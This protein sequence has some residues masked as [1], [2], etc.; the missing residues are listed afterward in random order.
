MNEEK[1]LENI[2]KSCK[3]AKIVSKIS[4][5]LLI[6]GTVLTLFSGIYLLA[7]RKSMDEKIIEASQSGKK[8]NV[9]LKAGP[10]VLGEIK[11][12][13]F[14]AKEKVESSNP[15]LNAY[16]EANSDSPSLLLGF[17]ALLIGIIL[18]FASV[19]FYFITSIFDI[20]IKEGNPFTGKVIK[21]TL[22]AM[23][24]L[25]L[26]VG[27]NAGLAF[28]VLLGFL[29]WVIYTILDYGRVLQIQSDETL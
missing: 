14:I 18:A 23:I 3:G 24:I 20:I 17:Y 16:F 7:E 27:S 25:T 10:I 29:T 21:R 12:G 15:S 5:I 4:F 9:Q 2:K 26:I 28:G 8:M 22:I 1:K 13:E 19:A 11:D 6:V